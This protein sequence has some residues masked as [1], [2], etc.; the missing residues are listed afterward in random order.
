M[1]HAVNRYQAARQAERTGQLDKSLLRQM[2]RQEDIPES[3]ELL[4]KEVTRLL[5]PKG[6]AKPL[7][8]PRMKKVVVPETE[9]NWCFE[10]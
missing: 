9:S 1:R 2:R 8:V 7:Y 10:G 6:K 4:G 3:L 5:P